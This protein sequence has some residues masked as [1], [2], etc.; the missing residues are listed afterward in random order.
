MTSVTICIPSIAR[1]ADWLGEAVASVAHQTHPCQVSVH[2]DHERRGA[3]DARNAAIA[4]VLNGPNPP[5]WI[6][7]LDDDDY[8]LPHH[9]AH[10]LTCAAEHKADVVYPWF[11]VE[12]GTDPFPM[13]QGRQYD[14]ADPHIFPI[15]YLART[16]AVRSA[17]RKGGFKFDDGHGTWAVQD[18][19]FVDAL[20]RVTEGRFFGS[21]ERTWVWRHHGSNTSGMPN[22]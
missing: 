9:V 8:L 15:T 22:R 20:W 3:W 11:V 12:G 7:F 16:Y 21:P 14:P 2:L 17:M 1:R 6:G 10:L 4:A 18:Q 5:E 19:P 13:H